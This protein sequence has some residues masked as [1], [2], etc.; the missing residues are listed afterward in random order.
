MGVDFWPNFHEGFVDGF[1]S[2][3]AGDKAAVVCENDDLS[4]VIIPTM[5]FPIYTVCK[6]QSGFLLDE[7]EGGGRKTFGASANIFGKIVGVLLKCI[8]S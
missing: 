6:C 3:F 7:S 2:D 8:V 1:G 5:E 4:A